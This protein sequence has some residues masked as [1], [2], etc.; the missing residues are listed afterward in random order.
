MSYTTG[1][2]FVDTNILVYARDRSDGPK[3]QLA[4]RYLEELWAERR[5][6]ISAQVLNEYYFVVTHKLSRPLSPDDAQRDVQM[7]FAWNPIPMATSIIQSAWLL[8]RSCQLNWWDAL[9]LA[10]AQAC[11]ASA[12]L[13]KDFSASQIYA[14]VKVINPFR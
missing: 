11:G 3:N 8:E 2:V 13:S 14:G 9:I 5:G 1:L 10:A 6:R 7:Y 12:L 4:R